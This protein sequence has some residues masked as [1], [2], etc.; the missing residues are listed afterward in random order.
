MIATRQLGPTTSS[1][2]SPSLPSSC[3]DPAEASPRYLFLFLPAFDCQLSAVNSLPLSPFPAT[4]TSH[5]HI[6]ENT[7]TLSLVFATLTGRVKHKSCVCHSYKKHPGW[8]IPST[9]SLARASRLGLNWT[10]H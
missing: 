4:L 8:G 9:S 1:P 10:S 6:I 7:A 5:S 2:L 3:P